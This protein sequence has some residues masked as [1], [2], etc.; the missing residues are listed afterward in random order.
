MMDKVQKPINSEYI[1]NVSK[2]CCEMGLL[3]IV[4][5]W[6]VRQNCSATKNMV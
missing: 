2:N 3:V 6:Q 1:Y 5:I 4:Y